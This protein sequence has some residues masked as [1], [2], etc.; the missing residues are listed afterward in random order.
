MTSIRF[1][2]AN[3][4]S[5]LVLARNIISLMLLLIMLTLSRKS[6]QYCCIPINCDNFCT[7]MLRRATMVSGIIARVKPELFVI[8]GNF[9]FLKA[10][11]MFLPI[12]FAVSFSSIFPNICDA[13][14]KFTHR[15]PQNISALSPRPRPSQHTATCGTMRRC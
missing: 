9:K 8:E 7:S 13:K 6:T 15:P 5:L 14:V 2:A 3:V 4:D 11:I 12:V 10:L 1:N